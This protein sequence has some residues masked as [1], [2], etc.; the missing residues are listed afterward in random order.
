MELKDI[1]QYVSEKVATTTLTKENYISTENMLPDKGGI[2]IASGVPFDNSTAFSVGDVLVSNIRPYFRKIWLANRNGGCSADVLCFRANSNVDNSYFYYLLSQQEFFDYIMSG[3]KGCK[4]PRGDKRQ[5]MQWKVELPPLD[6]Q[7][8]IA[9][10]LSSL[11][12]KIELNHRI[13][14]NLEQQAQ[15]LF[16][17]WFVDFE[18]FKN[19]KFVDSELGKIPEGWKVVELGK[20]TTQE[21]ERVGIRSDVK[22]LS[23][24][25]TGKLMLSEEYFTKQVFSDSIAK[26]ILVKPNSFAY[27]PARVNIGSMGRNTFMFDGCVSPVYVVF[28]CEKE[29]HYFL[30]CIDSYHHLKKR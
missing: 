20:V 21:K 26:Y 14:R 28:S 12:S 5:I 18:P 11:D 22:V 15:A 8:H 3:A 7:R 23:P 16:K 4:M 19:G 25:T 2:V 24:V 13:N 30:I 6:E 10:V 9:S 27:N 17:A 1:C 29:Y